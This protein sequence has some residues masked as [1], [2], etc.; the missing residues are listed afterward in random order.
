MMTPA[1]VHYHRVAA[2]CK[3]RTSTLDAAF[4]RNPKRLKGVA[5]QPPSAPTAV[6]IN[7]P[8]EEPTSPIT[9]MQCTAISIT[10]VSQSH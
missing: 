5:P 1:T 2:V 9:P 10:A 8:T 7:P 4:A 6:W 3:Q